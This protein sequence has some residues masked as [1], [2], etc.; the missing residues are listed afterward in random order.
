M[1]LYATISSER[2][3][4]GQGGNRYLEIALTVGSRDEQISFGKL[5]LCPAIT[6]DEVDGYVLRDENDEVI[7]WF[8][9]PLKGE[10]QKGEV[11]EYHGVKNCSRC[12]PHSK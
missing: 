4:K 5:T 12:N 7:K 9:T 8:N 10:K 6:P 11:C 1:K 3:T 2:A